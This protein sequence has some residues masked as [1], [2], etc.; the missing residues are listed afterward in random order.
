MG[1]DE[2]QKR[3][4]AAVEKRRKASDQKSSE[5]SLSKKVTSVQH[6][7]AVKEAE[8]V[9]AWVDDR[10]QQCKEKENTFHHS[11]DSNHNKSKIDESNIPKPFTH[12]NLPTT[13]N[14]DIDCISKQVPNLEA[15][16]DHDNTCSDPTVSQADSNDDLACLSV[17]ETLES[18]SIDP[19]KTLEDGY[20]E[21]SHCI[22]KLDK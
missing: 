12:T 19:I 8:R 14:F 11:G 22:E 4:A 1:Y 16:C 20:C 21:I 2:Q 15:R 7:N 10:E 17:D 3:R 13:W 18:S 5:S 6:D 9:L